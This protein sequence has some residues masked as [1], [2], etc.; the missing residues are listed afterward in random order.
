MD[1]EKLYESVIL[2]DTL[3]YIIPGA[4]FLCGII[5]VSQ[6]FLFSLGQGLVLISFLYQ[7]NISLTIALVA[8]SY[9]LGHLLTEIRSS[10]FDRSDKDYTLS[11]V[12]KDKIIQNFLKEILHTY[13]AIDKYQV[14]ENIDNTASLETIREI[15]RA[16][17]Y[18]RQPKLHREFV[19]RHSILSRFSRNMAIS[20]SIFFICLALSILFVFEE[21]RLAFMNFPFQTSVATVLV[22]IFFITSIRLFNRRSVKLRKSMTRHTFEILYND[23]IINKISNTNPRSKNADEKSETRK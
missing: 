3:E 1:I 4:I 16:F 13:L 7:G 19:G 21:I 18:E 20:L 11:I 9:L 2:R 6:A 14:I 12:N 22:I 5:C 8:L 10:Y 15:I 23:Y 17:I